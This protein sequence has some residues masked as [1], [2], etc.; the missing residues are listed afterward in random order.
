MRYHAVVHD[1]NNKSVFE[2]HVI[3]DDTDSAREKVKS[4]LRRHGQEQQVN[5]P[6]TLVEYREDINSDLLLIERC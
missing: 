6:I 2:C 3:S 4:Y 1:E 5:M